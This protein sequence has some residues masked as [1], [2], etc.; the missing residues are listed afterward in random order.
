MERFHR[1]SRAG[2]S[3]TPARLLGSAAGK[4][5]AGGENEEETGDCDAADLLS[6]YC[7]VR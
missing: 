1:A 2:S 6:K 7:L 4:R 3:Q 5:A